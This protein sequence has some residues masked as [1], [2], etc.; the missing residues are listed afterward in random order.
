VGEVFSTT[1]QVVTTVLGLLIIPL[2]AYYLM[3]DYPSI[4]RNITSLFPRRYRK[5]VSDIKIRLHH[6]FGGFV[7][8]QLGVSSI[9]AVYYSIAL[10]I[11]GV[12]LSLVLGLMAGFFNIIPY[13]GILSVLLLTLFVGVVHAH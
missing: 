8:G 6:V 9:L 13:V 5:S 7:R 1:V 10:T 4:E 3:R 12:E 11:A 2:M